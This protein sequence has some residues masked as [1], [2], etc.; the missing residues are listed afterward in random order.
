MI[1]QQKWQVVSVFILICYIVVAMVTA[2]IV[3]QYT[4]YTATAFVREENLKLSMLVEK[5]PGGV[6]WVEVETGKFIYVN[7]AFAEFMGYEN[8]QEMVGKSFLSVVPNDKRDWHQQIVQDYAA[9]W[10]QFSG[11]TRCLK[12]AS[13]NRPD[14]TTIEFDLQ[15][16]TA[17]IGQRREWVLFID[18]TTTR[19]LDKEGK[20]DAIPTINDGT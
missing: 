15:I 6:A 14:G 9:A 13:T 17:R 18:P 11:G 5:L 7:D 2:V 3:N 12:K 4:E 19:L 1:D 20:T 8:S 16:S 10:V